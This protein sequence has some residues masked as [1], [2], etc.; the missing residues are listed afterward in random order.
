MKFTFI[1]S[2]EEL[3]TDLRVGVSLYDG[4][5]IYYITGSQSNTVFGERRTKIV[6]WHVTCSPCYRGCCLFRTCYN[7][8]AAEHAAE[9]SSRRYCCRHYKHSQHTRDTILLISERLF[10]SKVGSTEN[11]NL[12]ALPLIVEVISGIIKSGSKYNFKKSD[13]IL[14][15]L[16]KYQKSL[17]YF[18]EEVMFYEKNSDPAIALSKI[19]WN[20]IPS[21]SYSGQTT[22]MLNS[23]YSE[24]KYVESFLPET[25]DDLISYLCSRYVQFSHFQCCSNCRRY[26]AFATDSKI[27]N[28]PRVI[29]T[30]RY[31][32]D[33][34]KTCFDV[35]R[36]R[37]HVR[38]LYSD[39]TQVLYQRNYKATFA[40]KKK[41]QVSEDHFAAWSEVARAMRDLC[42]AG[43]ITYDELEKW[44]KD[45]YLRE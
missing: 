9:I 28:C 42:L 20:K 38:G 31:T 13:K 40:R 33:I 26:F 14:A 45:N 39:E 37:S 15:S 36:L 3:G 30:A 12:L 1:H 32:K 23:P 41:G 2:L 44:F 6:A 7:A 21:F 19:D 27:K 29:E 34:G 8:R 11:R 43:E 25:F 35:G 17:S 22:L 10:T 4:K 18:A 16:K 5:E 24:P